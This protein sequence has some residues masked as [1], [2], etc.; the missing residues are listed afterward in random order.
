MYAL[1]RHW[2]VYIRSNTSM[3]YSSL[4][5]DSTGTV[6]FIFIFVIITML[7][8]V[9]TYM[10]SQLTAHHIHYVLDLVDQYYSTVY[11]HITIEN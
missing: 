3:R 11:S 8:L 7:V 10:I 2:Y 5:Y 1:S 9:V 6:I 4:V